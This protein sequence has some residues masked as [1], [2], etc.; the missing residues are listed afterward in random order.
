MFEIMG[1]FRSENKLQ[2]WMLMPDVFPAPFVRKVFKGIVEKRGLYIC[3]YIENRDNL[4]RFDNICDLYEIVQKGIFKK[5]S[6][7]VISH[8]PKA[9]WDQTA[10]RGNNYTTT[11]G[12]EAVLLSSDDLSSLL[13]IVSQQKP[14]SFAHFQHV[15]KNNVDVCV[16]FVKH[17]SLEFFSKDDEMMEHIQETIEKNGG[18]RYSRKL[19]HINWL[20]NDG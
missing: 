12:S 9:L 18:K 8:A 7:V 16:R 5:K 19:R 13:S 4:S 2:L 17:S 1:Y 14:H 10:H 3:H 6:W 11:L 15:V 20:S